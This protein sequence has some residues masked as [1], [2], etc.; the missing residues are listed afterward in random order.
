M[1]L[2][3][4]THPALHPVRHGFFTRKGGVSSGIYRGLN[5]GFGSHDRAESVA[6]NRAL[7]AEALG[8]EA[9]DLVTLYQVH[10]SRVVHVE[11][12]LDAPVQADAMVSTSAGLVLGVLSADCQPV[13]L[14]DRSAG[15]I[16]AAHAGWRGALDGVLG[17]TVDAMVK[18]GARRGNMQ[19][20]IGPAISQRAYEV[21][22]EFVERFL[23]EDTTNARFFVGGGDGKFHFDL[24]GFG[25]HRLRAEGIEAEWIGHCTFSDD[26]KFFSYRRATHK[27]QPDYGRLISAISL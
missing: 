21:G 1:T 16:G 12:P 25:L 14:L 22:Q 6:A 19:A 13:L 5:C 10:S 9:G 2:E 11:A 17:A 26:E 7:V 4:L 20:V 15:V 3:I 23:D 18:L 24:P 27:N 8:A